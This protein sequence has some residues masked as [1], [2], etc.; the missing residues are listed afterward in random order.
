MIMVSEATTYG[1]DSPQVGVVFL[2]LSWRDTPCD[3][4]DPSGKCAG[5]LILR[6]SLFANKMCHVLF[7]VFFVTC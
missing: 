7:H 4:R 3:R 5:F 2:Y 6:F 1:A